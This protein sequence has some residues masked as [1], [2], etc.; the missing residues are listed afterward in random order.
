[1]SNLSN[2]DQV[3]EFH[4]T[5]GHPKRTTVP[6][7]LLT[8]PTLLQLAQFRIN[9]IKE[10]LLELEDAVKNNDIVEVA[11][12]LADILY[13][14][15]GAG[16]AFGMDLDKIFANVHQSNMSKVC[17]TEKEAQETVD[18]YKA[19]NTTYKDPQYRK[20]ND[21]YVV[22][23]NATSKILKNIHWNSPD[24]KSCIDMEK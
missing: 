6:S 7:D 20:T 21:Y 17:K 14:T 19:N 11:D 2:F 18:Y 9:L 10:E 12:A 8:T 15:Y 1:M 13:V 3:G 16:H 23:D 24:I 4:E 5:F 22:Y